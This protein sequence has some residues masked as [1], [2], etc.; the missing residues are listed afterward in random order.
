MEDLRFLQVVRRLYREGAVEVTTRD[1]G[2]VS[3]IRTLLLADGN[4]I[5]CIEG[6]S[7]GTE[8]LDN[9]LKRLGDLFGNLRRIRKRLARTFRMGRVAGTLLVAAS[10]W[11]A[12][13]AADRLS[14]LMSFLGIGAGGAVC[15]LK[16]MV[17]WIGNRYL[18]YKLKTI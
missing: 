7:P 17:M 2:G 4:L 11:N 15:F 12:V 13:D 8:L 3:A 9:H 10:C 5:T 18:R 14:W 1:T 6:R 16:E